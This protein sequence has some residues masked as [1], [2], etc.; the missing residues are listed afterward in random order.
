MGEGEEEGVR[1]KSH[2]LQSL[3]LVLSQR[4]KRIDREFVYKV[5]GLSGFLCKWLEKLV[6]CIEDFS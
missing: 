5:L 4:R 1:V 3:Q 2:H 6:F